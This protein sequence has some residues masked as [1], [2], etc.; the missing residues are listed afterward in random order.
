MKAK[1]K[2]FKGIEYVIAT[3]LPEDQ[4]LLLEHRGNL[5]HIKILIDGKVIS[6]CLS[7]SVYSNWY[8]SVFFAQRAAAPKPVQEKAFSRPVQLSKA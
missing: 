5:E 6:N 8:H 1:A 7:Y 2:N 3:E 4:Q